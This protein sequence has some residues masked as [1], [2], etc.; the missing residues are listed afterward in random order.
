MVEVTL[1]IDSTR[2]ESTITRSPLPALS[3]AVSQVGVMCSGL[4]GIG[5]TAALPS[6]R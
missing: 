1:R 2:T 3:A 6:D 5:S 4:R